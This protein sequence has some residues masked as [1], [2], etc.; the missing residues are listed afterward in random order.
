LTIIPNFCIFSFIDCGIV[1]RFITVR[2][3]CRRY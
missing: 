1:N 2:H 3:L